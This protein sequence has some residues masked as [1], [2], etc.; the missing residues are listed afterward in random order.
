MIVPRRISCYR[1][2]GGNQIK[3]AR[4]GKQL[5]EPEQTDGEIKRRNYPDEKYI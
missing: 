1:K 5:L 4:F 3:K 2:G